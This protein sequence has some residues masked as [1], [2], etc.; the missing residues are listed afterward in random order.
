MN[1]KERF[2]K[3]RKK[4]GLKQADLGQILK[5][6]QDAISAIETG[7]NKPTLEVLTVLYNNYEVNIE[8][9][10]TGNGKMFMNGIDEDV[11]EKKQVAVYVPVIGVKVSPDYGMKTEPNSF[12]TSEYLPIAGS[13]VG[14]YPNDKLRSIKISSDVMYPSLAIGDLVVFVEGF[15]PKTDGIYIVNKSGMLN[16]Q[17]IVFRTDGS[18]LICPDNKKYP[19]EELSQ[20]KTK[21]LIL[22]GKVISKIQSTL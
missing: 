10:L 20:D 18:I 4:L 3:I 13:L 15:L 7:R 21:M 9:L 19:Q 6:S 16:A 1:V 14:N 17:R 5:L 11:I 22:V 2:R 8:W 12:E